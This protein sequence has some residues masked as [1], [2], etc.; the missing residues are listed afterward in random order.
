MQIG[1]KTIEANF[2]ETVK[3]SKVNC[4]FHHLRH[5]YAI[6]MLSVLTKQSQTDGLN[7]LKTLQMLLGHSN[8]TTTMIY[9]EALSID[10]NEI[11]S[12]LQNF[13]GDILDEK[14]I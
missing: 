11:E 3:Q 10:L 1:K 14:E 8:I 5:T 13:Y 12:S 4:T 6:K 7:P 2:R 9:L